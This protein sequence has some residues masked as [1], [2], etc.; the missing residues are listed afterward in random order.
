MISKSE[1]YKKKILVVGDIILDRYWHGVVNR[2]S[3][4]AP[5]PVVQVRNNEYRLGG[6]ANVAAN[7]ARLGFSVSLLGIVGNDLYGEEIKNI[8]DESNIDTALVVSKGESTTVK[9]RVL[10]QNQQLIRIDFDNKPRQENSNEILKKFKDIVSCFDVVVLSDYNK[11][12]LEHSF[13]MIELAKSNNVPVLVDPKGNNYEKYSNATI[14]T[15]NCSELSLVIGKWKNEPDLCKKA[16]DLRKK[17]G[18][19]AILLTRSEAG[20]TIFA[21]EGNFNIAAQAQEVFDVSGA[22]D[23]I[24]A[25]TAS[26]LAIGLDLIDA[27]K[28]ANRAAGLVVG[29]LGTASVTYEELFLC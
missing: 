2:I 3:P 8:A 13:E 23:T 27:V 25:V 10:A 4:E 24:I 29:K 1:F 12:V 11:G 6:A 28:I 15:P 5:V 26:M 7:I 21:A 20:V 17:L 18:L 14:I 22:G 9:L 16:Q 19:K